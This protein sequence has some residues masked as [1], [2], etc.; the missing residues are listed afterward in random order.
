MRT[1][2]I[3]KADKIVSSEIRNRLI[4]PY[5][6]AFT[7]GEY[8][9]HIAPEVVGGLLDGMMRDGD[10]RLA[11][12]GNRIAGLLIAFPLAH[13]PEKS[14]SHAVIRVWEKN[15]PAREFYK[16]FEFLPIAEISQ[17]KRNVRNEDFEMK[18]IYLVKNL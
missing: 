16:R 5:L 15:I 1:A 2:V 6:Y 10:V 13:D 7:T 3:R 4:D 8:A 17:K 11:W 18:K 12:V 9:Q 14:C